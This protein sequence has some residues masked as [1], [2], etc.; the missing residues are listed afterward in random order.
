[1]SNGGWGGLRAAVDFLDVELLHCI[2]PN[3]GMVEMNYVH[4]SIIN[5]RH[6]TRILYY[7]PVNVCLFGLNVLV[8]TRDAIVGIVV[9]IFAI[10]S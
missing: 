7:N 6:S 5:R 4:R 9:I 10:V 2:Y 3:R 1:M 8:I